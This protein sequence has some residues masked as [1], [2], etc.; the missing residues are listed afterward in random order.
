MTPDG[1]QLYCLVQK[2]ELGLKSGLI[3]FADMD[4]D[5]MLDMVTYDEAA[6]NI[7]TYYNRH[8]ANAASEVN[9]CRSPAADIKVYLGQANS[10]FAPFGQANNQVVNHEIDRQ[11]L[12]DTLYLNILP[13]AVENV[14]P[15][16]LR[17]GDIDADGYP[18]I[19][20]TH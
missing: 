19:L 10:F 16:R 17:I 2:D 5:G 4:R 13:D 6:Q 7:V 12:N 20:I 3:E 8:K 9:L 14:L 11:K 18:D 1:A 15:G